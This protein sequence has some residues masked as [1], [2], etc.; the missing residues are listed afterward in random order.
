MKYFSLMLHSF[1]VEQIK[2]VKIWVKISLHI[3]SSKNFMVKLK[4]G[5]KLMNLLGS[6]RPNKFG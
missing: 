3:K 6:F 4:S 1:Y 5:E 2:Q